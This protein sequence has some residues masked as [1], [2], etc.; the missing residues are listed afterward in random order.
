MNS[1]A[2]DRKPTDEEILKALNEIIRESQ[3]SNK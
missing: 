2:A 3:K 1:E